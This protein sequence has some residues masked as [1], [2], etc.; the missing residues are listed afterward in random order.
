[1]NRGTEVVKYCEYTVW[2]SILVGVLKEQNI[3]MRN[4]AR[5]GWQSGSNGRVPA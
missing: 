1:M 2:L 5:M 3:V 4:K